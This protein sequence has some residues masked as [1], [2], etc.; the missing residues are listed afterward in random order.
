[1]K[2]DRFAPPSFTYEPPRPQRSELSLTLTSAI[3]WGALF[4]LGVFEIY[5]ALGFAQASQ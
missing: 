4:V 5:I 2:E 3:M 1:M